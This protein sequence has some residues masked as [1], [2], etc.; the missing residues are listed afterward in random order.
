M[1]KELQVLSRYIFKKY[2]DYVFQDFKF[3]Y[4][5]MSSI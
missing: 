1:T 5:D 2:T 4:K 3:N